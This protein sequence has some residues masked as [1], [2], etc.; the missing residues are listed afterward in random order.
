VAAGALAVGLAACGSSSSTSTTT[1]AAPATTTTTT[2][3]GGSSTTS[4]STATT[5]PGTPSCRTATLAVS[6]GP[7]N[8]SAGATH[9]GLTFRNTGTA[10]CTLYGFPGVSFLDSAGHQIGDPAQRQGGSPLTVTVGPGASAYASVAVTDPGIPPCSGSTA[11]AQVVVYP[12]GE[13][14]AASV[15]AP[16][17]LKV[18][19]SPNT[20]AYLSSTVS[21]VSSTAI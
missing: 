3:S 17:G 13:T 12:P 8:G 16:S 1:T 19:S 18:C 7:P 14:H 4:S 15:A 5:A 6:L 11:A 20:S 9:Y 2:T 10:T 21:P